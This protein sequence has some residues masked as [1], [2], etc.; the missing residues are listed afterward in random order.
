MPMNEDFSA[1]H[2]W[3]KID[4]LSGYILQLRASTTA[5][6]QCLYVCI[7]ITHILVQFTI[8]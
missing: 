5:M 3:F 7:I 2:G 1:G 4:F 8:V 6:Q